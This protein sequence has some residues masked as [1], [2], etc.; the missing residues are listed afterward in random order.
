MK[1][2]YL[3]FN[4]I[5]KSTIFLM[6][7]YI[8]ILFYVYFIPDFSIKSANQLILYDNN[9]EIIYQ[10]S[11]TN[12]WVE[13]KDISSNLID[14]VISLEDK[15]FYNHNGFDYLRIAKAG[16][17][18]IKND[19]IIEGA[20]TISQ[21]LVKNMFL[22][23]KKTW[24]RKIKEAFLT[25][26]LESTYT[27]DEILEGYLNTIN[28]GQGNYGIKS[29]SAYYFNKKP[30]DLTIEEAAI[31]AGIPKSPN[32]NNPI[33][34]Y[35][36]S[37]KRAKTVIYSMINNNKLEKNEAKRLFNQNINIYGIREKNNLKTLMYYQDAVLDEITKNKYISN[38]NL[39]KGIKIYTNLD[40]QKQQNL[41]NA[42]T[43]YMKDDD[44]Q[45]ASI[46]IEPKTGK[47]LALAGG[48]DYALSQYNRVTDAKRQ[49]GS[50]I[51]PLLYYTALENGMTSSS[52]FLSEPTTFVFSNNQTYSPI[53]YN[54][55]YGYQNITMTAA[56]AYSE[57]IFAV[58]THLFLGIDTLINKAHQMGLKNDLCSNPALA[59]GSCEINMLDYAR[60]YNTLANEGIKINLS[61]ID[62]IENLDGKILYQ[63]KYLEEQV[64]DK[65]LTY[66]VNEMMTSTYNK[67]FINYNVPTLISYASRL[68]K[69]YSIKTGS[70]G[71]DY[72]I[73]GYNP[74]L[75]TIVWNGKDNNLTEE[76]STTYSKVSKNIWIDTM[77]NSLKD[78]ELNWY[79][80]PSNV[81]A[82]PRDAVTGKKPINNE[83]TSL[84]YYIKGT[85]PSE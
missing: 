65:N 45:V 74:D 76:L 63:N 36:Q 51:K 57:N 13:L 4:I 78:K 84:Y 32:T 34:N 70:T 52:T 12:E 30:S 19:A 33:T 6:L 37:I 82:I 47:I 58:K 7:G 15:N 38:D 62:R 10:G 72:M 27:K 53:N 28:F 59:L 77:E 3:V 71:T 48:K 80:L 8:M 68:T 5:R 56:L 31:L 43:K 49:V 25:I 21:Q 14:A 44:T 81:V 75:L 22:S 66:I 85:E 2:K 67:A 60:A 50:T 11:K 16:I 39:N 18:N 20:S 41:E 54:N 40:M 55:N 46:V 29:A 69:K 9:S 42:I 24:S 83:N 64:L 61:T 1:Y 35:E 73:V 26:K 79:K 23:F 17:K